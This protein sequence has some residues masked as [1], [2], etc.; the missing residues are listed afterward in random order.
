MT[1]IANTINLDGQFTD[2]PAN[3]MIMTAANAV[4]G[5]QVYGAFLNDAT[6]G[7][8]Y[9]IGIDATNSNDAVIG[10][11]TIIYLNTDQ[12]D[13]TGYSPFGNIGA[14]YYVEFGPDSLPYLYSVTSGGTPTLLNGGAPIPFGVSSNGESV[15]LAIAQSLLTPTGASA[16]TSINFDVLLNNG[17]GGALPAV[18]STAVP[19]F[20]ISDPAAQTP[21]T[22]GNTISLDGTFTDWPAGDMVMTSG[23][24]VAGYQVFGALLS[25]ASLG[26][27]YVI[28]IDATNSADSPIGPGTTIYLDTDQNSATGYSPFG[29]VGENVGAEYEV[30]FSYGPNSELEPFLYSLTSNGTPTLVNGGNPLPF[31]VS[32]NGESVELAIPQSDLT[33]TGGTAP[34]SINFDALINN[35]QGLPTDFSSD[36]PYTIVDPSTLV[37]V[38]HQI[39]KVAIV[40]SATTAALY[41][42]GGPAGESAYSDLFMAAQQQARAAGVS[43]D[44]LTEADLTNVANLSQYSAIIFPSFQDVQSSQASAIADALSQVVYNYH[45]PIITAGDFMTNDQNGNPLP[46]NPYATMQNLLNLTTAG[47]GT[48][49]Y[50]VTPDSTALLNNNPILAGYTPG[51]LIGGASGEFAGTTQGYYTNTGYLNFT[52]YTQPATT[53]A[54]INIQGGGTVAGV[55]QTTT[56]GTNT[57]FATTNLMGDSNLLQHVIQNTVFGTTPSLSIDITRFNGIVNSRTDMD[58]SQFPS[59][60]SP[61]A[62]Q[63][64]V[65]D[66]LLNTPV[67]SVNSADQSNLSILAYLQQQYDFVGSYY[68]N[69]GDNANPANQNSTNWTVSTPYYDQ[70]LQMGNEIGT[71]SYT[72][73]IDPSQPTTPVTTTTIGTTTAGATQVNVSA[74]PSYNGATL[75]MIVTDAAGD[76]GSATSTSPYYTYISGYSVN[77]AGGYTLDLA[78]QPGGYGSANTGVLNQIASG[79][80]LDFAI[81]AENTNFLSTGATDTA[82]SNPNFTYAYEF[83]QSA[84]TIDQQLGITVAGAAVPGSNDYLPDSQQ[85]LSYFPS[86]SG[87]LTGYVSGGWTGV[88][89]GSPNAF[90]Y[91]TPGNT[92]SV[93][94]A[95]NMTF[96]FSELQYEGKT[97][98][99]TLADWESLFNQVSSNSAT[100]IIVWPWHDYGITDWPTN[101]PGTTPPGYTEALYQSFIQY[102][103]NAGD[104]F[105]TT[106][107]LAQ[108]IAAEQAATISESTSANATGNAVISATVTPSAAE[109]DL[110]AMALNVVNGA[111]GQ[112]IENAGAWY[113]YDTNSVFL[114]NDSASPTTPEAFTVTLGATQD[115]VTH[116]D[117]LPMR[118]DLQSATGNGSNLTFSITGDGNVDVHI[119]TPSVGS[120]VISIQTSAVGTGA[121]APTA[122]LSGDDLVLTFS[123]GPLAISAASPQGVPVLHTVAITEG[124]TAVAGATF[125]FQVPQTAITSTG[126]LTNQ[127]TQTITGTVTEPTESQVVGTT[128]TLYDNGSTTPLGTAI[129]QAGVAGVAG[130]LPTWTA[131]VNLTGDGTH[132]IV[133]SDTDVSNLIGA[134]TPPV[135]YTLDTIPPTVTISTAGVATK[136]ATQTISGTVSQPNS[137]EAPIGSTV[138][139]YD[140]NVQIGTA[141]VVAP[142]TAGAPS[143]WATTV[144]LT[145]DGTHSITASDTD[146]AGNIGSS[147]AVVYTLDT[148]PPLV[149]ISNTSVVTNVATQT[150]SGTVSPANANEAAVGSTVTLYDNNVQIGMATVVA[151]TTAGAPSTWSTT[152]TLTGDG[153]HSITASDTD[154]VGN[155]GTSQAVIYTLDTLPPLVAI[156]GTGGQTNA[157]SLTISGTVTPAASGEAPVGST[158]TLYDNNVQIGTATVVAPTTAG[159]P[160]TWSATVA[161]TGDGT[162]SITASDTDAAG[163]VGSSS[164]VVY[165]L[166]TQ[167]PVVAITSAGGVMTVASQT[168]TGT[169]SEPVATEIVGTTVSLFDNGSTTAIGTATVQAGVSGGL[170]TWSTTVTLSAGANSIVAKATDLAGN[171]G[172]SSPVVYTFASLAQPTMTSATY[173]GGHWSLAGT[174]PTGATVTVY[175]GATA[176][177]TTIAT[178]G[179][180]K[181][182]TAE[183]NSAIRVYT[184]IATASGATSLSSAPYYEGTPVND[185]FSFASEAAVSAAALINGGGGASDTIQLTSAA[186]LGDADFAH[187]QAVEILGLT[188]AS[189]VTLGTN[190]SAAGIKTVVVGAGPTS[191]ADSN[192]G[193]LAVN[194][195][196]L[197]AG[198]LLT[199]TGSTALTVSSLTGNLNATGDTGALSVTATGT[200]AQNIATGSGAASIADSAAGGSV[201]VDATALGAGTLTLSGSAAETVNNLA[202]S[203]VAT[204]LSGALTVTETGSTAQSVTTGTGNTT[205]TDNGT[206]GTTVNANASGSGKTLT[207]SGSDSV[208]VTNLAE[209]IV[210]TG[211]SGALN[212]TTKTNALSIATGTGG[213][214]VNAGAM[215]GALTLTG[216][217]AA[218]V[219]ALKGNLTA[220]NESGALTVT[221]TGATQTMT[222]GSG[223]ISITDGSSGTLT[224]NGAAL[225]A[226]STA[227]VTGSGLVTATNLKGNLNASGDS[228]AFTVTATGTTSQ[229]ITTGS[230]AMSIA[231]SAAGGSVVVDATLLGTNTLTLSG[232]AAKT[233][234]N[235]A[236][237]VV[238]SGAGA[239]TV[240]A[241]GS[242]PQSVTTGSGS[243]TITDNASGSMTVNANAMGGAQTLTLSGSTAETV[244]NVAG[245][246][247]ATGLSGALNV[248]TKTAALS[249]ATGTGG[250]TV[251]AGAMT[252]TLTLTGA[253]AATV[254]A[255]GRNLNATNDSG[256]LTVTTTGPA[257]TVTTGSGN[258]SITDNSTGTLTVNAA[259][260]G[261]SSTLTLSGAGAATVT[262]GSGNI[263]VVDNSAGTLTVNGAAMVAGSTLTVT[264]SGPVTLTNFKGNLNATGDTGAFT[265]TA[266]GAAAQSITTGSG[267]MSIADSAAG[268]SVVVDATQLGTNTLTLSGT[269]AST[270]NNLAG[271]LVKSGGS[272]TTVTT[273]TATGSGTQSVTTAAGN[274]SITDNASGS[275]T[276]NANATGAGRTLTLSGSAAETVTNLAANIVATGLTGALSV[277]TKIN[278]LS[279]A[280]GSGGTTINAGAMTGALTL[281][282]A[283]AA[284]V[285]TLGGNLTATNESGALTVTTTGATQTVTTGSGNISITDNSTGVLTVNAAALVSAGMVTLAGGG[286]ATVTTGAGNIVINDTSTGTLT[287][288]AA[289]LAAGNTVT[290]SGAGTAIVTNLKGA[291]N[292]TGDGGA[293]TVTATGA[294]AQNITTGSG[295]MSIA[296][297]AAGSSVVVD[298]TALGTG[299]L[300]TLS[301]SAAKTVNNLTGNVAASGAGALNI[302]TG[303]AAASSITT[304][305][306]SNTINASAMTAGETLT[307]NGSA[308]ATLTVGGNL[309]AS[310]DT[311][312]LNVTTADTGPHT[313]QTGSGKDTITALG[314]GDTIQ[315]G[316]GGDAIN[317]LGHTVA[318][319]FTYAAT[320]DSLNTS[321]GHDTITGFTVGG[322]AHDLL[323]FSALNSG[324]SFE[325]PVVSGGIVNADSIAFLYSGGSAMVYV[326]NT[327]S[328]V[329][330][331]NANLMEMTLAGVS[332]GLSNSHFV[333]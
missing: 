124:A 220:T 227:T 142:T 98:T 273:V 237:N 245:S 287:V 151:P 283:G 22:I 218:T 332:S 54:D 74:L 155:V 68:I 34:T 88:G 300:L 304:G 157:P 110:G 44:L 198:N 232:S 99:S 149:A 188:G 125:V 265:V 196:G 302:T 208:T 120:N 250:T 75:G 28:G 104:E 30:V 230:A 199:L 225:G 311:G 107:D 183:N 295:A 327:A 209:N 181:F 235:L 186:T 249:I 309:A 37:S 305:T 91:V 36:S 55:E 33:P 206:G 47:F 39:K 5:Y 119:K 141:T 46:G 26:K 62:G 169:V 123:D 16:P 156:S 272:A 243:T 163:N 189:G 89:S 56:G 264:G 288:N 261:S 229:S 57:E 153:T 79:T 9:V 177:G 244:T 193:T 297:S 200:A 114:A 197:G 154:A 11:G 171:V 18:F 278:A 329:T 145:G 35:T 50:S 187:V 223:N 176:L 105:V 129:V 78:Y 7:N 210:A 52:G 20:V 70:L 319:T 150:I 205:I 194:A 115:D 233:V 293:L 323:N 51:Q 8:T 301:G 246:I 61:G 10:P 241:T 27:T 161:L 126:G 330:T 228:G 318:D 294:T 24:A 43:Y 296:D 269:A 290:L 122:T 312:A 316:G 82:G 63:K 182:T 143:T 67:S 3:Y 80:T 152:V 179:T 239:L 48:S 100:P 190:A 69:I 86:T 25:D 128:V 322:S 84:S 263:S 59:D 76:L 242:G 135:V 234:N 23:N 174:A 158:V 251:N 21:T 238:A 13:A 207:L 306:G 201:V 253:G 148:L 191:I 101:G 90:G 160:S 260:L 132:S 289:A 285:T 274:T 17:G 267:A 137:T 170:P 2:W 172:A 121:G 292:A 324:L 313:I 270:V 291:L 87:G 175:D 217:G 38:N 134:S 204:A 140:N 116:V 224:V 282:G 195:A 93:Y 314:G 15:E 284:I 271:N 133:A 252:G 212:V 95:P 303:A 96:D 178:A 307:L 53:I 81:P 108:R 279:I 298:A 106:E 139:L 103:Y 6:L 97:P 281:T 1:T 159:A 299:T 280:T 236:G 308:A 72:H 277:T 112:V 257:Q 117:Y 66:V 92:S 138:T 310:S 111:A 118:A 240:N 185:V 113:A 60:V 130:G 85:I 256:A 262:T 71:H 321:T 64:G 73:L 41:D 317:V 275:M 276:V 226:G 326:N 19:Q 320:S 49:T 219:T 258:I 14:E 166:D 4:A 31:G 136:V 255:L 94:I 268:G 12:N 164:A 254:T 144:T 325:G 203:V 259:A 215:T 192:S 328:S 29:A 131:T 221:T 146:A 127:A 162:H 184:V 173:T 165:T 331:T 222:T 109:P 40:Y 147:A 168:I 231:D 77:P 266:T 286:A 83:G 213:T 247:V 333:A 42:G 180:W 315:G 65:Y 211:L 167:T 216:A 45:V 202:G 32:S 102:A 214:T 58:Q 248:T